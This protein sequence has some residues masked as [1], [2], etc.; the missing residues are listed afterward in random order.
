MKRLNLPILL[1]IGLVSAVIVGAL[2]LNLIRND[3]KGATN[4]APIIAN[5]PPVPA[6]EAE[7]SIESTASTGSSTSIKNIY[8]NA[9]AT[10][11]SAITLRMIVENYQP[12]DQKT[13]PFELNRELIAA[14]VIDQINKWTCLSPNACFVD[15]ALLNL[16]PGGFSL[17]ENQL[18]GSIVL[19]SSVTNSIQLD[20]AETQALTTNGESVTIRLK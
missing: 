9:P 6:M 10:S 19:D 14:G 17:K 11:Y 5:T 4:T 20:L 3:S 2:L 18:L 7:I 8:F 1:I 16:S 13:K 15:I 12:S